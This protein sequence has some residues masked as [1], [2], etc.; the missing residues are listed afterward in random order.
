MIKSSKNRAGIATDKP[1]FV[2]HDELHD[3]QL[4]Q[5]WISE[6]KSIIAEKETMDPSDESVMF[7]A[8]HA[9]GSLA[10]VAPSR[11]PKALRNP[12]PAILHG[13]ILAY[14]VNQNIG[15]IYQMRKRSTVTDIDRDDL[16]SEGLWTLYRSVVSFNPWKGYRF[17]TYACTSILR[18]FA[19]LSKKQRRE[20]ARIRKADEMARAEAAGMD[21]MGLNA[22]VLIEQV[23]MMLRDNSAGLSALER[24]VLERRLLQITNGRSETLESI[25]K[26]IRFSKERVRQIQISAV[27]KLRAALFAGD[28]NESKFLDRVDLKSVRAG[29]M[30]QEAINVLLASQTAA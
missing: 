26:M 11:R 28:E 15:L 24:F 12:D 7:K 9:C 3:A 21:S 25:G 23:K 29:D 22:E 10:N 17:S 5:Q 8:L 20:I 16:F 19:A 4:L 30:M 1:T 6:A 13:R 14:L 2:E 18:A 27:D